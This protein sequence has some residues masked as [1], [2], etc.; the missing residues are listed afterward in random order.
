MLVK[1]SCLVFIL[2]IFTLCV[3]PAYSTEVVAGIAVPAEAV[4]S[5]LLTSG[6][7]T[8]YSQK[9]FQTLS[10]A[11]FQSAFEA[12]P[13]R[14][15]GLNFTYIG[16]LAEST[17][18]VGSLLSSK[19]HGSCPGLAGHQR[20]DIMAVNDSIFRGFSPGQPGKR[21][22]QIHRRTQFATGCSCWNS[23]GPSHNARH[24]L[25]PFGG[26]VPPAG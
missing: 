16:V 8:H 13:S 25:S 17:Y 2:L 4:L 11:A 23:A 3:P 9:P 1:C 10:L 7:L 12:T 22:E 20:P 21:G 14:D 18:L 15:F 26:C 5:D 24:A 19:S 6:V